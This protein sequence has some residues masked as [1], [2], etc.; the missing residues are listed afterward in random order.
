MRCK[1]TRRKKCEPRE[2]RRGNVLLNLFGSRRPARATA[3]GARR[4]GGETAGD[5]DE[6]EKVC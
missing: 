1:W 5:G 6:T 3:A 4:A 2:R